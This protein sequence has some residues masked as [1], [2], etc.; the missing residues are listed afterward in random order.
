MNA[1]QALDVRPSPREMM[2]RRQAYMAAIQ[3]LIR[4]KCNILA[5]CMPVL[6]LHGNGVVEVVSN[7]ASPAQ[8]AVLDAVDLVIVSMRADFGLVSRV[9]DTPVTKRENAATTIAQAA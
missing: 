8:Q 6:H 3:P 5:Y 4:I 7:G 2:E 1:T 9:V